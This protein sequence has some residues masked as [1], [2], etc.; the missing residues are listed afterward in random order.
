M[1]GGTTRITLTGAGATVLASLALIPAYD[2]QSWFWPSVLTVLFVAA[3]GLALRRLGT[4]MLLIPLAQLAAMG[5][6]YILLFARED[7]RLG[8]LPSGAAVESLGEQIDDG[9]AIVVRYAA[10]VPYDPDLVLVTALGVGLIAIAVDSLAATLRLVPWAGLP[11]LLLYSIPATTVSGGISALAFAPAAIGYILML[12]SESRERIGHWGRVIGFAESTAGPQEGISTSL[13]GQ[14]GRR[15]GAAVIGLAIVVPAVVPTLPEGILGTGEGGGFGGAGGSSGPIQVNNPVVDLKRN[16]SL[17]QN[18]TVMTYRTDADPTDLGYIRMVVLDQFDGRQWAPSQRKISPLNGP[19]NTAR[20]PEPPGL[21][22]TVDRRD[23]TT[24]FQLTDNLQ[25]KWLPVPYPPTSVTGTGN[26]GYDPDT[27]DIVSRKGNF[28]QLE[29]QVTSLSIPYDN[30]D[31]ASAGSPPADVRDR[32]LTLPR[33]VPEQVNLLA[34]EVVGDA[35][36]PYRQAVELQNWFR[37]EFEYS[38]EV[39][40]GHGGSALMEFLSDKTGYCEQFSATMA[41][42]ARSLGIPARVAVGYMKG[43][44]LGDGRYE[45]K[46]HDAHAWP[47]LYFA[48]YGWVPFEPTPSARTDAAPSWTVPESQTDTSPVDP[49]PTSVPQNPGDPTLRPTT[50]PEQTPPAGTSPNDPTAG[51]GAGG[52][53]PLPFAIG[54]LA[55][56]LLAIPG[57]ARVLIRRARLA[58]PEPARL[59]EGCW[60][61]LAA[62]VRDLG[63]LWDDAATPRATGTRFTPTVRTPEGIAALER[64]VRA[65]EQTRYAPRPADLATLRNDTREVIAALRDQAGRWHRIRAVLLPPSLWEA[66]VVVARPVNW[67]L[68][69]IDTVGGRLTRRF[70]RTRQ[71]A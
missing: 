37:D 55:L 67:L 23:V 47:E 49:R 52:V 38:L 56:L 63:L 64:L 25:P 33:D 43:T 62:S 27:L 70:R 14:T 34:R 58:A 18:V 4:P 28:V 69:G 65:V 20:L 48:G 51:G 7:L 5:W 16:L 54:G 12:T 9:L 13:L 68:D 15:V 45:V 10:P 36:N 31:L 44:S 21:S 8:F 1:S 71:E 53:N 42:M 61:E 3:I 32:Y 39:Q 19:G 2:D 6:A 22:A 26:W 30:G 41:I 66:V 40:S 35:N 11:L 59:A 46:A 57:T 17:G 60:R 50:N 29:Y 24:T